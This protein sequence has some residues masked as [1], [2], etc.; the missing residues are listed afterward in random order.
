[1]EGYLDADINGSV[2]GNFFAVFN[3]IRAATD[4]Q[5]IRAMLGLAV[6]SHLLDDYE[7]Q[8]ISTGMELF[9]AEVRVCVQALLTEEPPDA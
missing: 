9:F 5:D 2:S 7:Q 4:N 6:L 8:E 1:M 3:E